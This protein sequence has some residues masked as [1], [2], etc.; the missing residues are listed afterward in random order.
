M[1]TLENCVQSRW[2]EIDECY[3]ATCLWVIL[4]QCISE[5]A[6]LTIPLKQV[7]SHSKP[8]FNEELKMISL[9]L[10]KARKTMKL[11][12]DPIN[13]FNYETLKQQFQ[14][15]CCNVSAKQPILLYLSSKSLHTQSHNLMKC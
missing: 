15:Y 11:R 9:Q 13:T 2:P 8:Y 12:S 5:A 1:E 4:L 7:T 14:T 3:D 6:N 10:R